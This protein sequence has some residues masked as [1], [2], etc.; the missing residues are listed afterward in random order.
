MPRGSDA[1]AAGRELQAR[2]G[3][4][5]NAEQLIAANQARLTKELRAA[6]RRSVDGKAT[7]EMDEDEAQGYVEGDG[8]VVAWTVRGPFVVVVYE[9]E[10]GA[11]IKEAHPLKGKDK[12]AERA[13]RT[14]GGG[15][16]R[17]REDEKAEART[18]A[19]TGRPGRPPG[20][21]SAGA[22]GGASSSGSGS[23]AA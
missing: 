19:Q 23:A 10:N 21:R 8:E 2:V 9:D 14:A 7:E 12:Q 11:L 6:S 22:T 17:E 15:T 4:A 13:M 5:P 18:E 20:R 1:E 3:M 16:L